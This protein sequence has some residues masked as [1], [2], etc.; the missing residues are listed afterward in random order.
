MTGGGDRDAPR[1]A[2]TAAHAAPA[3]WLTFALIWTIAAVVVALVWT[4]ITAQ[5]RFERS[6][7]IAAA[8]RDNQNRVI[9]F[10]RYV[11]RTLDAADVAA[12]Y[13]AAKYRDRG[14]PRPP[15]D[16]PLLIQDPVTSNPLFTAVI[17]ADREGD[18][19]AT[20]LPGIPAMNIAAW[21]AVRV[22]S[23]RSIDRLLIGRPLM[24]P[25]LN[26]PM[27]ALTRRIDRADGSFGGTVTLQ[28][29]VARFI[30][31][32]EGATDRNSDVISVIRLDGITIA[33]R[34]GGRFSF[35]ENL[36]GT[37]VMRQQMQRPNG[38][39]LGPSSLDGIV[40]W[41]SHRRLADYPIFVTSGVGRAEI[42]A[43][44]EA[45]GARYRGGGALL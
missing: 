16:R 14:L 23:A 30:A 35:G 4:T 11:V 37:L 24:S 34:T 28:V 22:L 32:T 10:E 44:V 12:R 13:L 42:L 3:S 6:Q 26:R 20:T 38:T 1:R 7:T 36:T 8:I 19:V 18:V 41:F 25:R 2:A 17:V 31:F 39:Y 9:A 45:R 21:D 40:R 33:R 27:V 43:P 29:D 15:A 5:V